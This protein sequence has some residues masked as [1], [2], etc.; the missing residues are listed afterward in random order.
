MKEFYIGQIF[1][2]VYPPEAAI[3]CNLN[4][5]RIVTNEENK[6]AIEEVPEHIETVQEKLNR[7]EQEY[8]MNRWQREAILAEGS[9]YTDFTKARAREL[10]D[11]AEQ[12]RNIEE[13][14]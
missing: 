9:P 11:L 3:W 14:N 12:I 1:D 6:Y 7:L 4:N 5:A 13:E 2:G 10:E 8:Q